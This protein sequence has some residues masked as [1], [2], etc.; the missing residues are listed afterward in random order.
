M[1]AFG[2]ASTFPT[3]QADMKDKSKFKVAAVL[4]MGVLFIIYFPIAAVG[5]FSLGKCV[6]E[7]VI[8]SMS[9][10]GLKTAAEIVILL[11]LVAAL[12]IIINP[13]SQFFE[14]L[15]K[16][17]HGK[18]SASYCCSCFHTKKLCLSDFG[19]KRC[20][21]RTCSI[22]LLLFIAETVPSFGSILDLV[23]GS[24]ITCLTFVMP[25]FLYMVAMDHSDSRLA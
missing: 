17:P 13:P 3:I 18:K 16:I 15:L 24:T 4:A 2:G 10:G 12:P 6:D 20:A 8:E 23:G 1:F 11:H 7:N 5:Y 21:F 14:G 19:W 25:P 22:V 9:D